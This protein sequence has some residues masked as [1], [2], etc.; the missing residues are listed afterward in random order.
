ML[1][2]NGMSGAFVFGDGSTSSVITNT[3]NHQFRVRASG[4][5][6][7]FS[8]SALTTGVSLA[9]G[10][11]AW[12]SVS[13]RNVKENVG[14]V[15]AEA[16]LAEIAAMPVTSWN[17]ITQDESIRHI[18]PMAQDFYAAFGLG[19]NDTTITTTD[20]DGINMLAIQAL[21]ARTV[22]LQAENES[23][24]DEVD[25]LKALVCLDHPDAEVCQ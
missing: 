9:P 5:T 10:G 7:F 16:V 3:A 23:L 19:E 25:A 15:D 8:N 14:A 22:A 6:Q 21:E 20:I 24:R 2:Q 1:L 18:G 11:G 4:G 17:Y 13:D 12:A